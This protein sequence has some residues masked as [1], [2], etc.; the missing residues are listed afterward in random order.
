MR[1]LGVAIK[2]EQM[3]ERELHLGY[4]NVNDTEEVRELTITLAG[5]GCQSMNR[6]RK[7]EIV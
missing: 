3:K 6:K 4:L 1:P 7:H 2:S 5:D